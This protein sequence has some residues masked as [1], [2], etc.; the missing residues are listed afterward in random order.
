M[1]K[2]KA[3]KGFPPKHPIQHVQLSVL[4]FLSQHDLPPTTGPVSEF[5]FNNAK[6]WPIIDQWNIAPRGMENPILP[7]RQDFKVKLLH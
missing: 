5:T 2:E 1:R 6:P 7:A 3:K 4:E